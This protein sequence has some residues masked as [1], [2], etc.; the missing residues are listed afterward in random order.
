MQESTRDIPVKERLITAYSPWLRL[1]GQALDQSQ[2]R[3]SFNLNL[4]AIERDN[5]MKLFPP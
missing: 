5:R 4:I 3:A 2:L 1:I